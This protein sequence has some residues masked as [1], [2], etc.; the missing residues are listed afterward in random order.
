[1]LAALAS[2]LCEMIYYPPM[3]IWYCVMSQTWW[4]KSFYFHILQQNPAKLSQ[5][6]LRDSGNETNTMVDRLNIPNF[7]SH[8]TDTGPYTDTL[9][10]FK[11][12]PKLVICMQKELTLF[13][14]CWPAK[15]F[16]CNPALSENCTPVNIGKEKRISK[17]W[18]AGTRFC[19]SEPSCFPTCTE[20]VIV[21]CSI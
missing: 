2:C 21:L 8:I 4:L 18:T 6:A 20:N 9:H 16:I 17:S 10:W 5:N 3:Y 13:Q 1:M 19:H 14:S 12:V 15:D 7:K 11:D